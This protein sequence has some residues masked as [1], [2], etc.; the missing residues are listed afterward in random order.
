MKLKL[1]DWGSI[2]EVVS[3][4]A[5]VITLVFLVLEIRQG[6]SVTRAS[7]YSSFVDGLIENRAQ[8]IQDPEFNEAYVAFVTGEVGDLSVTELRQMVVYMQNVFQ[9]YEKA[10]YTRQYDL[11]GDAEWSRFERQICVA[12]DS[13]QVVDDSTDLDIVAVVQAVLTEQF[14]EYVAE[15]CRD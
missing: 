13:I 3:G 6:N 2:A 1:S 11:L 5:V 10:Y 15:I 4:I 14:L 12:D 7:M 8:R 9:I